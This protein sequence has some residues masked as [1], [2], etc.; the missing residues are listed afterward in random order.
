[1]T[2]PSIGA[3]SNMARRSASSLRLL[4]V[5]SSSRLPSRRSRSTARNASTSMSCEDTRGSPSVNGTLDPGS[6][7]R[8]LRT[9]LASAYLTWVL[10]HG[11]K[12]RLDIDASIDPGKL[13]L[14]PVLRAQPKPAFPRQALAPRQH[15][16]LRR[17]MLRD[18]LIAILHDDARSARRHPK[19]LAEVS[20]EL[21]Y[22]YDLHGR[23]IGPSW[24][25]RKATRH[26]HSLASLSSRPSSP[27]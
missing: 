20:L 15:V 4:A 16:G 12:R 5:R 11:T 2:A 27:R 7:N 6:E 13:E 19:I 14:A 1:M 25:R 8:I 22:V 18:R 17:A 21:G 26:D 9:A 3:R 10:A 23:I 24:S